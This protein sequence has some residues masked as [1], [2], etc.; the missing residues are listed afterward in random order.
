MKNPKES[1]SGWKSYILGLPQE[2]QLK[3][4][5]SLLYWQIDELK[6]EH[7]RFFPGEDP[8]YQGTYT[9]NA[10]IYWNSHGRSLLE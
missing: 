4:L 3:M 2:S 8:D 9:A 6:G 10:E 1:P 5:M 7:V